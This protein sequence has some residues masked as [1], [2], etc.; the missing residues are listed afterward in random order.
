MHLGTPLRKVLG[1]SLTLLALSACGSAAA[2]VPSSARAPVTPSG[3]GAAASTAAPPP[4]TSPALV[5]VSLETSWFPNANQLMAYYAQQQGYFKQVGLNVDIISG[6][7]SGLAVQHVAVGQADFGLADL[8]AMALERAGGAPVKA[9][10]VEFPKTPY[11]FFTDKSITSFAQLRGKTIAN[12]PDSAGTYLLP[13]TLARLGMTMNDVKV[14]DTTA[15]TLNSAYTTGRT[16]AVI[17]DVAVNTPLIDPKRPSNHLAISSLLDVPNIGILTSESYLQA[18][19]QVVRGMV[20]AL[21]KA[22]TA[23]RSDPAAVRRI[24]A[25]IARTQTG[26]KAADLV[27]SWHLYTPF[28]TSAEQQGHPAGW[29]PPQMWQQTID[30]LQRYGGLRGDLKPSDY[31]TNQ[32][33]SAA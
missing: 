30:V 4:T 32:F 28:A 3:G 19:P 20:Q 31:Y 13:A 11:V 7:G 23:I 26:I 29:M 5:N 21:S 1:L 27:T 8:T 6:K 9:I 15:A 12:A 10:F 25:Y 22:L 2:P 16:D 17:Q 14:I 33:F 24:S 18:H